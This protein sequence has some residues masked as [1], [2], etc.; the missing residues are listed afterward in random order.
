MTLDKNN[1]FTGI[2]LATA[3]SLLW[4]TTTPLI[5]FGLSF[6]IPPINFAGLRFGLAGICL[7]IFSARKGIW[8][9]IRRNYKI[10]LNVIFINIFLG[11]ALFY[12]GVDSISA[13]TSSVIMGMSPIINIF[14][15][16][17]L[18]K[19]DKL[20]RK[21]VICIC[22]S[23]VGLLLVIGNWGISNHEGSHPND[24]NGLK[25]WIG[26]ILLFCN[27]CLQGYSSIKISEYSKE[28]INPLFLNGVQMLIGGSMLYI[29]GISI[30][31][32]FPINSLPLSFYITLSSLVFI[33]IFSFSFW[34]MALQN[35]RVKVSE[36]NI[37]K[38]LQPGLGPVI[39]WIFI[40]GESPTLSSV[41]GILIILGIMFY[42]FSNSFE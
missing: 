20:N 36:L 1:R 6:S 23:F 31:G 2:I 37:C 3:A 16:H 39:S 22:I 14:L 4:A 25:G 42:Y 11:Y 27:I 24:I 5:K 40:A 26:I 35:R 15:A 30:E 19:S 34:F 28:K 29:L 17:F 21:K 8:G 18:A 10:F 32:Y 41:I 7:I 12:I 13:A 38:L 9:L 33:S